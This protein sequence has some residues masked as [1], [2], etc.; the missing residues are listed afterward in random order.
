MNPH[1]DYSAAYVVVETGAAT[2]P[3][4]LAFS[5]FARTFFVGSIALGLRATGS[6]RW[7]VRTA[8][9]I[10]VLSL[11]GSAT[12]ISGALFPL[13]ALST[14]ADEIWVGAVAWHWLRAKKEV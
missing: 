14:L 5:V 13:L 10:I 12:L 4:S 3:F 1:S 6:G 8:V 7:L 9:V 11:A 2:A